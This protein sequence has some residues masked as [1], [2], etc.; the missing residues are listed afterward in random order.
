MRLERKHLR[1]FAARVWLVAALVVLVSGLILG[2]NLALLGYAQ[3][4]DDPVGQLTPARLMQI[5]RSLPKLTPTSTTTATTVTTV[6]TV[7]TSVISPEP[8]PD[9]DHVA[10]EHDDD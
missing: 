6:T 3:P 1:V 5:E 9:D 7:T 2:A 4:R 10:G 8:S